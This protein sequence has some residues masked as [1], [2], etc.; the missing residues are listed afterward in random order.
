MKFQNPV[1]TVEKPQNLSLELIDLEVESVWVFKTL[2]KTKPPQR[3]CLPLATVDKEIDEVRYILR[4]AFGT[5]KAVKIGFHN[6]KL[7]IH[8]RNYKKFTNKSEWVTRST[9]SISSSIKFVELNIIQISDMQK[10]SANQYLS[11][12]KDCLNERRPLPEA[13]ALLN[14]R[15]FTHPVR[16]NKRRRLQRQPRQE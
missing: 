12:A 14:C 9:G 2:A 1:K 13:R 3:R 15:H 6:G 5:R 16:K 4:D 7:K 10:L 11:W 8:L